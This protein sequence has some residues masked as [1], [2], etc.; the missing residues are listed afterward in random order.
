MTKKYF[1]AISKTDPK[2]VVEF[3]LGDIRAFWDSSWVGIGVGV[4]IFD[5]TQGHTLTL[6]GSLLKDYTLYHL[7][8][9]NYVLHGGGE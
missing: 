7:E 1:R 8:Q 2:E 4:S 3:D 9:G 5:K 6:H